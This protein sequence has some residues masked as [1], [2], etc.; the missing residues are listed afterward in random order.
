MSISRTFI[1]GLSVASLLGVPAVGQEKHIKRADLPPAVEKTVA[2]EAHGATIKGFSTEKEKGQ[3]FYEAE[4]SVNGHTK[5]ILMN[6]NGAIVEVEEQVAM[7]SLPAAV[8]SGLQAKA[9]GGKLLRV[10]SL[11]KGGKLVAYEAVVL[12]GGK[13]TEVQVGPD[14]KLLDHEE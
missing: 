13:S 2:A 1:L 6:A 5:D 12:T 11:T 9:R 10:E 4:L 3:V 14:G 8:K 7:E